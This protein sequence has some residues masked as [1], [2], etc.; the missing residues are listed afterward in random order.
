MQKTQW[1]CPL[2][3]VHRHPDSLAMLLHQAQFL[4]GFLLCLHPTAPFPACWSLIGTGYSALLDS[5]PARHQ[6]GRVLETVLPGCALLTLHSIHVFPGFNMGEA[7]PNTSEEDAAETP[8]EWLAAGAVATQVPVPKGPAGALL[9]ENVFPERV[10]A[11]A[12]NAHSQE[13]TDRCTLHPLSLMLCPCF[14]VLQQNCLSRPHCMFWVPLLPHQPA[15]A[16]EE[17]QL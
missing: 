15:R 9:T 4:V 12:I 13:A 16:A 1:I 8:A 5:V 11:E 3:I 17:V 2:A 7:G 6:H 10:A 14:A